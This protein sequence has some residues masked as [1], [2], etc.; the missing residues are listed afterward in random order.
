MIANSIST[1]EMIA[2]VLE[3]IVKQFETQKTYL[4]KNAP[5]FHRQTFAVQF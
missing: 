3:H 5:S 1:G 2:V 4:G